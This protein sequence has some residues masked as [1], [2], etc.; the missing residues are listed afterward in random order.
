VTYAEARAALAAARRAAR[1]SPQAAVRARA[2]L[3]ERWRELATIGV[4]DLVVRAAGDLADR[5]ALRGYDAIHLATALASADA[6][7]TWDADL[8]AAGRLEGLA[9]VP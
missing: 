5:H 6:M 1:L 2:R 9:V 4:A 7:A 8:A 3:E